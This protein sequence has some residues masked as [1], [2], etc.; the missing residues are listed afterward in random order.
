MQY[1]SH[2]AF[3]ALRISVIEEQYW[4]KYA[5]VHQ[6]KLLLE[7]DALAHAVYGKQR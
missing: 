5:P 2:Y 6:E 3:V 1:Q 4:M 7:D